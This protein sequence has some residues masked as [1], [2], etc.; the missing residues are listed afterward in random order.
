[1]DV[2]NIFHSDSERLL[3]CRLCLVG[4]EDLVNIFDPKGYH[5]YRLWEVIKELLQMEVSKDEGLP[6]AVCKVCVEKVKEF[7]VFKTLCIR[8]NI[9]LLTMIAGRGMVPSLTSRPPATQS[10]QKEATE[11]VSE[12][13]NGLAV[14]KEESTDEE[15]GAVPEKKVFVENVTSKPGRGRKRGRRLSVAPRPSENRTIKAWLEGKSPKVSRGEG[16]GASGK[17]EDASLAS[18]P[19]KTATDNAAEVKSAHGTGSKRGQGRWTS[20]REGRVTRLKCRG[21]E[22]VNHIAVDVEESEV[23]EVEDDSFSPERSASKVVQIEGEPS[24][25]PIGNNPIK[26][27]KDEGL[28]SA[29]CKV[30]VEKVKEFK[31]FKTLCIRANIALLTMIA[32]RGMVSGSVPIKPLRLTSPPP[33]KPSKETAMSRKPLK[34]RRKSVSSQEGS[35]GGRS[36]RGGEEERKRLS[37]PPTVAPRTDAPSGLGRKPSLTSRPPATQSLQKEATEAVSEGTNGLAVCKEES[38]DEEE[39]AVPE[40]KVFVENVTSKP[41]RGR[42]RGR[43]LSVAPRPSENRTIKAWLEGKSPKVSRG[44]GGGAS[45]KEEDASLASPPKKTAT[46]NAAE[47]KS[48]H[49]TGSKRGRGRARKSRE[50]VERPG[51][52]AVKHISVDVEESEVVEVEDEPL[53]SP[54]EDASEGEEDEDAPSL[55]PIGSINNPIGRGRGRAR[56]SRER[57]ERPGE[58]AVKHISVDAMDVEESEVVEV[59]DEP[60]GSPTEDASEGEED[61]DAPSLDPIGSIN[62]PIGG[63]LQCSVDKVNFID[64]VE[65]DVVDSPERGTAEEDPL[66]CGGSD[67]EDAKPMGKQDSVL[68]QMLDSTSNVEAHPSASVAVHQEE[69]RRKSSRLSSQNFTGRKGSAL[70]TGVVSESQRDGS[71]LVNQMTVS[72][73]SNAKEIPPLENQRSPAS[74][75]RSSAVLEKGAEVITRQ[76]AISKSV[77]IP[78]SSSDGP[79]FQCCWCQS[80]LEDMVT[81]AR[82]MAQE[83][84]NE[85]NEW[86]KKPVNKSALGP[87]QV[88]PSTPSAQR[89]I[90][91]D[92]SPGPA[93]V[94]LYR[95][96]GCLE[97]FASDKLCMGVCPSCHGRVVT[98]VGG[99]NLQVTGDA[100]R[101]AP[102]TWMNVRNGDGTSVAPPNGAASHAVA[103]QAAAGH[104][105]D[106]QGGGFGRG[107][108]GSTP[109]AKILLG[110]GEGGGA[111][112]VAAAASVPPGGGVVVVPSQSSVAQGKGCNVRC[113]VCKQTYASFNEA[114]LHFTRDHPQEGKWARIKCYQCSETFFSVKESWVHYKRVHPTEVPYWMQSQMAGKQ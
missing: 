104:F 80:I 68:R 108:D 66:A 102:G 36:G 79:K 63:D 25:D 61:E 55:D 60:L 72:H 110:E 87:A 13:T 15:E 44:E 67:Q 106:S 42:K 19:K 59:E 81:L 76:G 4:D 32:G 7:K 109:A 18:P 84:S 28:P 86:S 77:P 105:Q 46:D 26:V 23:V 114:W 113:H 97:A 69:S 65:G 22:A 57:V 90:Q 11:A 51:E 75:Q 99:E 73:S 17:E 8:A 34:A 53:G 83:H 45:G 5:G 47:V 96:Q 39:G 112:G 2:Q 98:A 91:T 70:A 82:H 89:C 10:L 56:R 74:R 1:M 88:V 21:E 38:T 62:N 93:N 49:G 107:G 100:G 111:A 94:K 35:E 48:A 40:K 52:E 9:A 16:G 37:S 20:K 6:S 85:V 54:T 50:R 12:G 71:P 3:V 31:V 58:E 30:C 24:V 78:L 101:A 43:R 92:S 14:C 103:Q 95:C 27:S 64:A 41:G 29:V 33:S